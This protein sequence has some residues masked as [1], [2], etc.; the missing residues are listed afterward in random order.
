[1]HKPFLN[2]VRVQCQRSALLMAACI[3]ASSVHGQTPGIALMPAVE[4]QI[5]GITPKM[6]AWR[7]DIHSHPEL[8]NQEVRTAKLVADHLR[9]LGLQVQTGVGGNGVVGVLVGGKPGKTVALRADMDALPV[10]EVTN[11]PFASKAVAMNMGQESPVMHAC[12]HDGHTAILMG[13]AEVLVGMKAQIPGTVKFFF[14]PA[15]EGF[16]AAPAAGASNGAKAMVDQ[17]VM[18]G[19]DAVFGL[20]I[21]PGLP[22]GMVGYRSGP[23][24]A[25]SDTVNIK[26]VGKQTH[27]AAPWAGVDPIVTAA[28]VINSLQTVVSRQLD[29]SKEPA[30]LT[31]GSI[32]GGNRE[33]IV[34]DEVVLLGTL[35]TFDESMRNDA[36]RR[37]TLT[38]ENVALANGAKAQVFFGPSEYGVTTNHEALTAASLPALREATGGKVML[39]PKVSASEDFSEFQKKGP[40]FFYILGAIPPGKTPATAA[41]N[42]SPA[43]DFDEAAMPVGV[44]TLSALTLDFLARGQ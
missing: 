17:G 41:P 20:H 29:I 37:I 35:R 23:L 26:I 8:S 38:A 42:H 15:E 7:R 21:S 30:V 12:G 11:L 32:H 25:G 36:K 3:A 33:N 19:V 40:G 10:A 44:R 5:S 34:P 14:Q 9:A 24:M 22:T 43:F 39:I 27:G 2:Q 4:Q 16:S 13:V 18:N 31:I 6:V 1:L 28:Q